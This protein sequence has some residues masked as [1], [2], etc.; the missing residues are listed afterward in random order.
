MTPSYVFLFCGNRVCFAERSILLWG[1]YAKKSQTDV[2]KNSD[3]DLLLIKNLCFPQKNLNFCKRDQ[4]FAKETLLPQKSLYFCK[5]I[6]FT[7][8]KHRIPL[9]VCRSLAEGRQRGI[10]VGIPLAKRRLFSTNTGS[11]GHRISGTPLFN[12]G[13]QHRK[14][15]VF[16]REG[17]NTGSLSAF[18][19]FC[20]FLC[21]TP[22]NAERDRVFNCCEW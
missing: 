4:I 20:I 17:P 8:V 16:L 6:P 1:S 10:L 13:I 19:S 11:L 2:C 18:F 14:R 12:R 15:G 9:C 5:K 7:W 21:K 22:A 3:R